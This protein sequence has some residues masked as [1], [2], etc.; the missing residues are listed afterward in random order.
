MPPPFDSSL[1]LDV[2]RAHYVAIHFDV[3]P[4]LLITPKGVPVSNATAVPEVE[5]VQANTATSSS[6]IEQVIDRAI[7]SLG[8]S[9]D[10]PAGMLTELEAL[11]R[12]GTPRVNDRITELLRMPQ[13]GE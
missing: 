12:D 5:D 2:E 11:L 8:Q 3:P 7:A 4:P 13:A 6:L 1:T 9:N 10:F